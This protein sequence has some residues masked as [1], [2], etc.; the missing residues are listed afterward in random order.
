[1]RTNVL[2]TPL[3]TFGNMRSDRPHGPTA[4]KLIKYILGHTSDAVVS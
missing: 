2:G 1:M 4:T 3:A